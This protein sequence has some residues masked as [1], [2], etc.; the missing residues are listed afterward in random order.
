[1]TKITTYAL[2]ITI[3]LGLATAT[4]SAH[5]AAA[6][7]EITRAIPAQ[8]DAATARPSADTPAPAPKSDEAAKAEAPTDSAPANE[9]TP[10]WAIASILALAVSEALSL[11][12]SLRS[13]GVLQAILGVV[14]K[15]FGKR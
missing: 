4:S 15:I 6:T 12:P 5:H 1:M 13:N 14:A 10:W 7:H 9:K 3:A 8:T 2:A 11:I